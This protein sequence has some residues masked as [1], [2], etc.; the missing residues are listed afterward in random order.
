VSIEIRD[1]RWAVVAAQHRS[2]RQ[3]AEALNVRQ[4]TLSRGLHDLEKGL[5]AAL[6]ERTNGGTW[7]TAE[8]LEFIDAAQHILDEISAIKDRLKARSR[9]E[10]GHLSVGVHASPS[11]GKASSTS[12]SISMSVDFFRLQRS[13]ARATKTAWGCASISR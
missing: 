8:G 12:Q 3:A 9:G 4:S 7:P 10:S 2:L 11:A 13:T 6:F 1:L 5:G